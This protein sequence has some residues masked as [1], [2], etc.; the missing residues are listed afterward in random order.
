MRMIDTF[1]RGARIAHD[2]P[3]LVTDEAT[4]TYAEVRARSNRIGNGLISDGFAPGAHGAVLSGND[5]KAFECILGILRADGVWV[6]ANNRASEDE[7]AYLLDLLDVDTLFVHSEVADRI[8]LFRR[9]SPNIRRYIALDRPFPE[10][11]A[12][13]EVWIGDEAEVPQRRFGKPE[14]LAFL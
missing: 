1:D 9:D 6:M 4:R 13:L 7:N 3:C 2:K 8:A 11:D 14:E 5:P 12:F 10:A